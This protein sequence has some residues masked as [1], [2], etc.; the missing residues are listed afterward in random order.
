L[1]RIGN[2]V[3]NGRLF[4][5]G[6]MMFSDKTKRA[7]QS[8][9]RRQKEHVRGT[10]EK[11]VQNGMQMMEG[12]V[13]SAPPELSIK[14]MSNDKLI[15]PKQLLTVAEHLTRHE[16]IVTLEHTEGTTRNLGDGQGKDLVSGDGLIFRQSDEREAPHND[17]SSFKYEYIKL[18]FEDVL[19]P[20]DKV[21]VQTYSG[22]QKFHISDKLF[23]YGGDEL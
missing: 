1:F 14:L 2:Q 9:A 16:R 12:V 4:L 19:K 7:I 13:I 6:D 23:S 3:A 10:A 8:Y 21:L 15:I 20:G 11:A 22:G 5:V 17:I 18:T